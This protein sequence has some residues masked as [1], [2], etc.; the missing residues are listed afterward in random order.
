MKINK[1]ELQKALEKVKPGLAKTEF[2]EQ[3][4]SFA[5][6]G[7]NVVTYNDEISISHPVENLD[8]TGAV[9]AQ[10][11]YE[12][13]NRIKDEEIDIEWEDNQVIIQAGK[14]KAG[15]VFEQEVVLPVKDEIGK[16]GKW[17]KVPKGFIEAIK[18]C[19]PCCS[20]DM[21]RPVLTCVNVTQK[22]VEASDSYQI[23]AFDMAGKLPV[24]PF[25]MPVSAVRELVK[26]DVKEISKGESWIHFRTED[27]TVF[28]SRIFM[29]EFP[30]VSNHL[31]VSGK[32]FNFPK[33]TKEML[34]RA[35]VFSK[36]GVSASDV[37]P[38]VEIEL[39]K[40]T[41]HVSA[42]NEYGWFK[43]KASVEYMEDPVKFEVGIQFLLDIANKFFDCVIGENVIKFKGDNWAHVIA[44]WSED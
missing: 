40:K 4:T 41:M 28:S 18:F 44:T 26:Y 3:T 7:G 11:L 31:E 19:Y 37:I 32:E 36:K 30:D 25:L 23:I 27:G 14:S 24:E 22:R 39:K 33:N 29:G 16:I 5:F 43:E 20:R 9:K 1:L 13:L 15:L 2:I 34:E 17:K 6:T 12:L 8:V 38:T 10:T 21:S 35:D 42:K